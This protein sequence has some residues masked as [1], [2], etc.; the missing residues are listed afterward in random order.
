ME[1]YEEGLVDPNSLIFLNTSISVGLDH[2]DE[3]LYDWIFLSGLVE[4]G[5]LLKLGIKL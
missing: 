3:F 5:F 4:Y 2:A 1:H